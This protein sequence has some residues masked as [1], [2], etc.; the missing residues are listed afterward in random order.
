MT[1][2]EIKEP[3]KVGE[4]YKVPCEVTKHRHYL[5]ETYERYKDTILITPLLPPHNHKGRDEH[6]HV[7]NRFVS[8]NKK[9]SKYKFVYDARITY[10]TNIEILELECYSHT[11]VFRDSV[12][13]EEVKEISVNNKC[14]HL[15][16]DLSQ[17]VPVDGVI[18]C[19]MHGTRI[20]SK[21]KRTLNEVNRAN[22][23]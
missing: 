5:D 13:V 3:L 11:I 19:P 14:P 23:Q 6:Y 9:H 22:I 1:T 16:Y 2:W 12:F 7:D 21:T 10:P 20:C 17:I 18:V 15:G 4:K 8:L